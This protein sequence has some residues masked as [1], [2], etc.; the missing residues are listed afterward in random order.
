M[1][2]L[3]YLTAR[4]ITTMLNVGEEWILYIVLGTG[5]VAIVY[6]SLGGLRAVI[7]T[8]LIQTILLF[9]GAW[10]V[11]ATI[12]YY[13]GG[14][15]WSLTKWDMN[16][17]TQPFFSFDPSTRNT[18]VDTFPSVLIWYVAT[19]YGDQVSIQRFMST[20]DVKT[21]RKSLAIQLIVSVVVSITLVL[22][23]FA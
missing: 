10:L 16:W 3:V 12:S 15:N 9:G 1:S 20:K 4:A 17:D 14:V 7:M 8:D 19:S 13:L 22:I 18:Y 6:T 5:S 23:G 11:I 21:A 2:I